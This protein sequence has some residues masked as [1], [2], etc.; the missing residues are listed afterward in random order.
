MSPP[1]PGFAQGLLDLFV[2]PGSVLPALRSRRGWGWAAFGLIALAL[3]ASSYAF[4]SPMSPEWIVE[5]QL[6]QLGERVSDADADRMRPQLLAMAP[7]AATFSAI[8]AVAMTGLL[9][10]LAGSLTQ[11]L[12]RM[13]TPAPHAGWGAWLRLT[14]WTQLPQLAYALG[15][16]LVLLVSGQDALPMA[17][18]GYASLNTLLLDLPP[19]HRWYTLALGVNL[20]TLW[21]HVLA[22]LGVRAWTGAGWLRSA[23]IA[24]APWAVVYAVWAVLA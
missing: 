13:L 11:G 16:V 21:S 3:A 6:L 5:Q 9:I 4:I 20:F 19:G 23:V 8:S 1:T 15:L 12:A 2:S 18:M 14:T 7:Y 22:V 24:L 10:V 17:A